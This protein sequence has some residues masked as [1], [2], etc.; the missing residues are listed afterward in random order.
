MDAANL[1]KPALQEGRSTA[2]EL[3]PLT[4]IKNT[5]KKMPPSNGA[6]N[7]F[8]VARALSEDAI[9]ILRGL[10]ERYEIFHGVRIT[11]GALHA[12]VFLSHRYITDR[13]LPDKAIDL[14]DEA[15][16]L[17]RM[18]IGSMPLPIDTKERELASSDR[19]TRGAQRE[20]TP[21]CHSENEKARKKIAQSKKS[22]SL[23]KQQWEQEKKLIDSLKEKKNNIEKLGSRKKKPSAR[24]L[25]QSRRT[26]L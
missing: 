8:M 24:R 14:I 12:A 22:S 10:K 17:I 11:E 1:L 13:Q 16:S 9:A 23:L 2:S 3:R 5:S 15:A 18:Q 7:P 25:Q 20:D 4:N 19:R 26:P 21:L 6:F